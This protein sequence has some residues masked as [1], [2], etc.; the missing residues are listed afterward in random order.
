[1]TITKAEM[2]KINKDI[3]NRV[4]AEGIKF[5]GE[6]ENLKKEVSTQRRYNRELQ[7]HLELAEKELS[8]LKNLIYSTGLKV[9]R[10]DRRTQ[11]P[12]HDITVDKVIFDYLTTDKILRDAA[13]GRKKE[14]YGKS[15]YK[16]PKDWEDI[17]HNF[18]INHPRNKVAEIIDTEPSRGDFPANHGKTWKEEHDEDLNRNFSIFI[19]RLAKYLKRN[20]SAIAFRIVLQLKHMGIELS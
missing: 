3:A 18:R 14:D 7:V 6:I 1:M 5:K 17:V 19:I 12:N 11:T 4:Y 13:I 20:P 15:S 8:H 9:E 2:E 16:A 10:L